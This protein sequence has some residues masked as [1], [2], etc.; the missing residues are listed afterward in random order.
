[1]AHALLYIFPLRLDLTE[2]KIYSVDPEVI[3]IVNK[4]KDPIDIFLYSSQSSKDMPYPA[5]SYAKRVEQTLREL[6]NASQSKIQLK[7]IDPNRSH[8][9]SIWAQNYGL[10]EIKS[11][12]G[13]GYYLGLV[14]ST[15]DKEAVIPYLDLSQEPF[16]QYEIAQSI[17]KIASTKVS[18]IGLISPYDP[19]NIVQWHGIKSLNKRYQVVPLSLSLNEISQAYSMLIVFGG[20]ALPKETVVALQEFLARGGRLILFLDPYPRVMGVTQYSKGKLAINTLLESW[21]ISYDSHQIVGDEKL[22]SNIL[23]HSEK[24]RYPYILNINSNHIPKDHAI[25]RSLQDLVLIEPGA[26]EL[27]NKQKGLHY[28]ELLRTSNRSGL[29][30]KAQFQLQDFI[31]NTRSFITKNRSY[32]LSYLIYGDFDQGTKTSHQSPGAVIVYTDTDFLQDHYAFHSRR[33]SEHTLHTPKNSNAR[34]LLNSI[35]FMSN[36]ISILKTRP[37]GERHRP[38]TKFNDL[39][40]SSQNKW[41]KAEYKLTEE[42]AEIKERRSKKAGQKKAIREKLQELVNKRRKLRFMLEKEVEDLK[43][44]LILLNIFTLPI[45]FGILKLLKKGR[46]VA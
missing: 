20:E 35:D 14:I 41:K 40:Q 24:I 43:F 13:Q 9:A 42:I 16:L 37:T 27:I 3:K 17:S 45:L 23:I 19:R 29:I 8:D 25:S 6:I 39:N 36:N 38:F 7:V 44:K 30:S 5:K 2:N 32:S 33:V 18:H 10:K 22:A 26:L 28:Q 34:L 1:M 12:N 11:K 31:R 4:I 21:G 46:I 15:L